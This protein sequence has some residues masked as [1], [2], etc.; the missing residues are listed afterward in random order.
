MFYYYFQRIFSKYNF[1]N[2]FKVY[3]SE[4]L[5]QIVNIFSMANAH[6]QY[7]QRKVEKSEKPEINPVQA[8]ITLSK[9]KHSKS[10]L[11][12]NLRLYDMVKE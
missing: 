4:Y 6:F 10:Y 12:C 11:S 1:L 8:K 5:S 3:L 9:N 2:V 7:Q